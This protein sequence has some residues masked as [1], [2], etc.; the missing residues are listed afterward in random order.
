MK[1][2]FIAGFGP[3]P[4]DLSSSRKLYVEDLAIKFN[5]YG[6]GYTHAQNVEG[7]KGFTIWPLSLVAED[8]FGTKIWLIDTPKPKAWLE[9]EVGDIKKASSTEYLFHSPHDLICARILPQIAIEMRFANISPLSAYGQWT[10][11]GSYP[12]NVLDDMKSF[13]TVPLILKWN[14]KSFK[15][16]SN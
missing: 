15:D 12:V 11:T 16:I 13:S 2:L 7:S 9:F 4:D 8:C 5:E 14:L 3:I 1:V 6:G 10:L